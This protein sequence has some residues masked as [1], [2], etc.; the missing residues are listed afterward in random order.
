MAFPLFFLSLLIAALK[1]A[2]SIRASFFRRLSAGTDLRCAQIATAAAILVFAVS[3]NSQTP[4]TGAANTQSN[5]TTVTN[6]L[7]PVLKRSSEQ[8]RLASSTVMKHMALH[9]AL[10][11]AQQTDM[12]SLLKSLHDPSSAQYHKWLTPEQIR[13][14]FGRS[15]EEIATAEAWLRA[16]GFQIESGDFESVRFSGTAAQVESA[17][18]TQMHN[19]KLGDRKF[20]ANSTAVTLP[21][22]LADMVRGIAHLN[23]LRP[24]ALHRTKAK[25]ASLS[26]S[27]SL[28]TKD[29]SHYVVPA[30][31]ETIYNVNSLYTAGYTGANQTIAVVGQSLID[32]ND[33]ALFHSQFG[34]NANLI[35]T[36][37]P[38]SGD[39]AIASSDDE[40]ESDLDIQY[41][42]SIAKDATVNFIFAGNDGVSSAFD[43]MEY[44]IRSD[45]APIVSI[46]YGA[47]EPSGGSTDAD[48]YGFWMDVAAAQGQTLIAASGDAGATACDQGDYFTIDAYQGLAVQFPSDSPDVTGVGGTEFNEGSDTSYW[49]ATD[50]TNEGSATGYIPE[51]VWNDTVAADAFQA[52][53]GGVSTV[54]SKP[55]WQTGTGVPADGFRDVPDIALDSSYYHDGYFYC[56]APDDSGNNCVNGYVYVGGGTS[57]AAPIYAGMQALI[58]QAT[59]STGQGN[60]NPTLYTLASS[61]PAV[62]HDITLGNNDSPCQSGSTDC[63][64]GQ[65]EIGYSATT[66]YD[67]ATGLGSVDANL[68]AQSFPNYGTGIALAGSS[69]TMTYGP[70]APNAGSTITF[71]ATVAPT[72]TS[73]AANG[74]VLLLI[75]GVQTGDPVAISAGVA[76]T[77]AG[78]LS[79]G[80]HIVVTEYQG[81]ATLGA[82]AASAVLNVAPLPPTSTVIAVAP[83]TPTPGTPIIVTTLTTSATQGTLT[84]TVDLS[85]DGNDTNN[86]IAIA[87]GQTTA[88]IPA[89]TAGSHTITAQYSGDTFYAASEG[90]VT[91]NVLVL[92]GATATVSI[93]PG[94]PS[95][96]DSV[97]ATVA[98]ASGATGTVQFLLDG[99][100]AGS[101]VTVANGATQYSLGHLA[102]GPHTVTAQY[103]GDTAFAAT[104]G[105]QSFVVS[106]TSAAFTLSA[107]NVTIGQN[108]SASTTITA[109]ST[110]DY[111]G[112][113]EL[114]VSG[115]G[116]ANACFL[117]NNNPSVTAHGTATALITI[118][119]GSSCTTV[120][121]SSLSSTRVK[122]FASATQP[123]NVLSNTGLPL[124]AISVGGLLL[125]GL[126]RRSAIRWLV[127]L[128]TVSGIGLL[129]GC[130]STNSKSTSTNT[131]GAT[132]GTYTLTVTGTDATTSSNTAATTFT[133]T[134]Q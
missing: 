101:P 104:T 123:A 77:S 63:T 131:A 39:A 98:I 48:S 58:N 59:A 7:L 129:G 43:A 113:V 65:T 17:F 107:T 84:G 68:L 121:N 97:S 66:G 127:L 73:A 31:I 90:L 115:S 132:T 34:G 14:R 24:A 4:A 61:T 82:S 23:S 83:T 79:S 117:V 37:L 64:S 120:Q 2:S 125:F 62:F 105:Q 112:M 42:G 1:K 53:G 93:T 89:L 10:T 72:S 124:G 122:R 80:Y 99:T 94:S 27:P 56:G 19:Y 116:P 3:A 5:S 91:F 134:V 88:T 67:Q 92:T 12:T 76:T 126:R 28:T 114:A 13:Q 29:G 60:I 33:V 95:T 128:A 9:F 103:S 100:A 106:S 36:L 119:A 11:G 38:D 22:S 50:G 44:A 32:P 108:A 71:T 109:A 133:L 96:T 118:Y 81:S 41:S 102:A 47:C 15:G 45:I 70:S 20:Y 8:G 110:T 40:A 18:Q 78:P 16:Q 54:F 52:S 26:A 111:A 46:S 57:F 74:N 51:M 30:D 85:V 55:D 69:T 75:D 25:V 130:G 86:P 87:N 6:S 35:M 49:S 21:K